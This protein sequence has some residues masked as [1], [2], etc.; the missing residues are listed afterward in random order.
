MFSSHTEPIQNTHRTHT[1]DTPNP[2]RTHT[3]TTEP[4]WNPHR[5]PYRTHTEHTIYTPNTHRNHRT[6]MEHTQKPQNPYGTH[7]EPTGTHP[8]HT[9]HTQNPHGTYTEP[10]EPTHN[11]CTIK[12]EDSK[13][14]I[15]QPRLVSLLQNKINKLKWNISNYVIDPWLP[16]LVEMFGEISTDYCIDPYV[17]GL[18]ELWMF[19]DY[20][21]SGCSGI[22]GA[23]VRKQKTITKRSNLKSNNANY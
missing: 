16:W 22:T 18:L 13:C 10:M 5:N 23:L 7:T 3:E 17:P 12:P 19:W 14:S 1:E 20:W 9:E 8:E 21:S 6:Y 15:A 2:H 11:L 4:I